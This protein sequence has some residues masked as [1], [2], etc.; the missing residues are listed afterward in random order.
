MGGL[1]QTQGSGATL[2]PHLHSPH[3]AFSSSSHENKRFGN[4]V[5][6]WVPDRLLGMLK[7]EAQIPSSF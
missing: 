5:G 4:P 6:D 3:A 1:R 2:H 7:G